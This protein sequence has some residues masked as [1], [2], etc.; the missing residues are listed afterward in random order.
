[1]GKREQNRK[2]EQNGRMMWLNKLCM[3]KVPKNISAT[4]IA[5][6]PLRQ[7]WGIKYDSHEV[8]YRELSRQEIL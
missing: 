3:D 8:G 2:R 1:M 7:E 4:P 5:E 6:E